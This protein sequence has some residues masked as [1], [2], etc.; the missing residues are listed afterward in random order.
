MTETRLDGCLLRDVNLEGA[1]V[2]AGQLATALKAPTK[3]T[4]E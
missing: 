2:S 4:I 3:K 1:I